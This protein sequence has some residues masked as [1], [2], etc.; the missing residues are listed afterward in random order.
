MKCNFINRSRK[1]WVD[2]LRAVAILLVIYG[3]CIEKASPYFV[4]T[5]PFKM[6][7]FFAISGYVFRF[8]N[9]NDDGWWLFIKQLFRKVFIPWMILGMLP[10]VAMIPFK[11][12]CNVLK[13][14]LNLL[15]G[16]SLWFMPCFF[17]GEIVWY[18]VLRGCK[19]PLWIT[20]AAFICFAVGLLLYQAGWMN[21]AM[22]NRALA[23]QPFF[24][25]GYLFQ[26]YERQFV[27]IKWHWIIVA[28]LCYIGLCFLSMFLFP[29]KTL[30]VH[31]NKY[32][33]I[34]YCILLIFLSC[35]LLFTAASKC[36]FYSSV[37]SFVGQN[38]LVIYIW[39]GIAI[40][41]LIKGMSLLGWSMP[42]NWWTALIK[43]IWA[44][45]VC[46]GSAIVLNRFFPEAIG[47]K[48]N[49]KTK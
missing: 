27:S 4:F 39:H 34:P 31:L 28:L 40:G 1:G 11:G 20:I 19:K 22:F 41:I 15:S 26:Q 33:N 46:G 2:A 37:M 7:L 9:G 29:G 38:T 23:V 16:E 44:C 49:S 36:N 21:Y 43:V 8:S 42:I 14:F 48:R 17:I 47:K 18:I 30:D 25:I 6:P 13:T 45:I 35:F 32:Y 10:A 3:H 24:L 5:S 12:F